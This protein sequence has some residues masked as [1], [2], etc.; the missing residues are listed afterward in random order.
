[1]SNSGEEC[2]GAGCDSVRREVLPP[3]TTVA[4]AQEQDDP[5]PTTLPN[6]TCNNPE[7]C[8]KAVEN[9]GDEATSS[10]QEERPRLINNTN[11][12]VTKN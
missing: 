4:R 8:E 9:I 6:Y 2:G 10:R 11:Q 3:V 1:M 5:A 12:V 7:E